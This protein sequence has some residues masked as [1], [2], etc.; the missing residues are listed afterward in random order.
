MK[1]FFAKSLVLGIIVLT[2]LSLLESRFDK[3]AL[4][5]K[6]RKS[7]WLLDFKNQ[8]FDFAFCGDSRAYN[9]IHIPT[10]QDKTG[11]KGINLGYT[12]TIFEE[13]YLIVKK[14]IENGNTIDQIYIQA[15]LLSFNSAGRSRHQFRV[16][17]YLPYFGT[18]STVT[19]VVKDNTG[20]MKYL[21]WRYVPMAKYIE[22]NLEYPITFLLKDFSSC[23][24]EFD[25]YGSELKSGT[26]KAFMDRVNEYVPTVNDK[27]EAK[28]STKKAASL[29]Y[30]ELVDQKTMHYFEQLVN[31]CHAHGIP[32][33]LY[34]PPLLN[35]NRDNSGYKEELEGFLGG[36][37]EAH[38]MAY[39]SFLDLP[40]C[41][42]R[43]YFF[44]ASHTNKEGTKAFSRILA[45]ELET[46]SEN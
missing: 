17:N 26:S 27:V 11:M 23:K 45:D 41:S 37:A 28:K 6:C 46:P 19:D 34:T 32:T 22:Y 8:H 15:D 7:V 30:D 20:T 43:A 39:K 38:D 3:K 36:I 31:Y 5:D 21:I 16:Y 13:Q 4:E 24:S 29:N 12:G 10:I 18:D 33:T 1:E 35:A 40:M 2:V 42:N 14:F 44:D 25:A 9:M